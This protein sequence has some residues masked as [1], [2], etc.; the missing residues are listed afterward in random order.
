MRRY[1]FAILALSFIAI[2]SKA[3][4]IMRFRRYTIADGMPQNS[5][6]TITQDRKGYIWIGSRSGLCRFD[7]L[8]FKQFSETSDGQ[9]I[10]WVHKI[11][12]ADDGETLILKIHGDKYYP[13]IRNL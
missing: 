12:I 13:Q 6:T 5:V 11:R 4:D 1:I 8:T 3:T 7:G 2:F 9:N 10:G